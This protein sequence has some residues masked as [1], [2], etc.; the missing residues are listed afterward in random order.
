MP[1]TTRLSIS[2]QI[3]RE[4]KKLTR[5]EIIWRE[6]AP[7]HLKTGRRQPSGDGDNEIRWLSRGGYAV[8]D[9]PAPMLPSDEHSSLLLRESL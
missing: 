3:Q 9:G 7:T 5:E 6:K 8:C 4:C 2:P 1:V